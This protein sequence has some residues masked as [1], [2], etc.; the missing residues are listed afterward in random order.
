MNMRTKIKIYWNEL[1]KSWVACTA[2]FFTGLEALATQSEY[3]RSI[4]GEKIYPFVMV[5]MFMIAR[6]RPSKVLPPKDKR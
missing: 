4:V 6:F 3:I 2:V 1:R 5:A